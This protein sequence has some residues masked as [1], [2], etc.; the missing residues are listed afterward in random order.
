[1]SR[2]YAREVTSEALGGGLHGLTQGLDERGQLSGIVNGIDETWDPW[3]DPHLPFHFNAASLEGKARI[4]ELVR[5]SLCLA[6]SQGPL[7]GIVSRLVP[8]KGLDIVA[9]VANDILREGGQIAIPGLGD[10]TTEQMLSR[11]APG[12]RDH[13]CV[14]IGFNEAMAR[15]VLAGSDF[16]LMPSRFEPCGL[17]QMQAQRYGTLPI[18]HATGGLADTIEDGASGFLF[19]DFSAEALFMSCLRA[20]DVFGDRLRFAEMR[21][22]AMS[23]RFG[24]SEA[25]AEY[26]RLYTRLVDNPRSAL[27][28]AEPLTTMAAKA[29]A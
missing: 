28:E 5:T 12:R 29:A 19:A 4:A 7:F 27:V 23:R 10:P 22:T 13:I 2:T 18:A 15:R 14:Q 6:P 8:Q 16:C 21:E 9:D 1:V 11:L 20:F 24:W 26:E 3:R 17:T 25:A